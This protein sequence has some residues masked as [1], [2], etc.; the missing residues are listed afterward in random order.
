SEDIR[1]V[2]ED[3]LLDAEGNQ[4]LYLTLSGDFDVESINSDEGDKNDVEGCTLL[5][6]GET[7]ECFFFKLLN[8]EAVEAGNQLDGLAI[9]FSPAGSA[10]DAITGRDDYD[11]PDEFAVEMA[12]DSADFTAAMLEGDSELTI[13]DFLEIVSRIYLPLIQQ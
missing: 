13:D 4:N 10:V 11:N 3:P 9:V 7:T 8:G 1:S 5:Q 2:W 12:N 6:A